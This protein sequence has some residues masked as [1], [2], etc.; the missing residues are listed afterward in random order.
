ML[1]PRDQQIL[2]SRGTRSRVGTLI[3]TSRIKITCRQA[4]NPEK[5]DGNIVEAIPMGLILTILLIVLLL[6]ILPTW[7]YSSSWGY[8][9][10]GLVGT[11]VIIVII[12]VL[13]GHI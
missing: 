5:G 6:A 8:Y 11:I 9:P 12:L 10:S 3:V 2:A 4:H 1:F 13:L 7:P